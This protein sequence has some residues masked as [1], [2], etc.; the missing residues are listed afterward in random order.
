MAKTKSR[1]TKDDGEPVESQEEAPIEEPIEE[2]EF[3]ATN[4]SADDQAFLTRVVRFLVNVSTPA[5]GARARRDGYNNEEHT[6]GWQLW[7]TAAG[8]TRPFEHWLREQEVSEEIDTAEQVRLLQ[9]IDDFENRWFP[10]TRAII[11]R[12]VPRDRRDRFA[13]AFFKDLAQQ[14]LGPAVVGS[15]GT[16]V[17]RLEG[18]ERNPDS[19]AKAVRATLRKRG[20]TDRR[21]QA[22]K[23]L[24]KE[25]GSGAE[26]TTSPAAVSAA[27]LEAARTAQLEALTD[28]RDWFND[29]GTTLR[30]RFGPRDQIR[31]GLRQLQGSVGEVEEDDLVGGTAPP[32]AEGTS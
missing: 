21:I 26:S 16:Y 31:L 2:P 14:P 12:V 4:L 13:A 9:E 19:D 32:A 17:T 15:V 11:R 7:R 10:R 6:L 29:W 23:N 1:K 20:L 8:E 24:L 22:I 3:A 5:L 28:L 27:E 25:A 18:L 30:G